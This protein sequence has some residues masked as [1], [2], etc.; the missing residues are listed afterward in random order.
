MLLFVLFCFDVCVVMV[1]GDSVYG[2]RPCSSDIVPVYNEKVV[3]FPRNV[4]VSF[5]ICQRR[6]SGVVLETAPSCLAIDLV[7]WCSI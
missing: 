2:L 4:T 1:P 6:R 7:G 3:S 5:H